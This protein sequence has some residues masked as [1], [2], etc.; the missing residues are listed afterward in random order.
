MH[1]SRESQLDQLGRKTPTATLLTPMATLVP[2]LPD[3]LLNITEIR[4]SINPQDSSNDEGNDCYVPTEN[5][6]PN[7]IQRDYRFERVRIS[8]KV[9]PDY[10]VNYGK[11]LEGSLMKFWKKLGF[12]WEELLKNSKQKF[13]KVTG[14]FLK[15]Y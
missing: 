14:L 8:L 3:S 6:F 7:L 11:N 9:Y 10:I 2:N 15:N 1:Q 12:F 5:T 13:G 4:A